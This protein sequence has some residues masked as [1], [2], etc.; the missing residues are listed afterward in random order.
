ML[1]V[2]N[3]PCELSSGFRTAPVKVLP[4]SEPPFLNEVSK[5]KTNQGAA[6]VYF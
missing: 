1:A 2:I 5:L 4:I 3:R 6:V